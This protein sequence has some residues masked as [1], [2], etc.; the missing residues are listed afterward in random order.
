MEQKFCR[1]TDNTQFDG[2]Y[3]TREAAAVDAAFE[4]ADYLAPGELCFVWTADMA[5]GDIRS[6]I[7]Q[8]CEDGSIVLDEGEI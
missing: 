4:V 2:Y 6:H 8:L 1:S 3:E 5:G 7:V